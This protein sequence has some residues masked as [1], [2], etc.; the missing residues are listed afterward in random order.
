MP[1][2]RY[3]PPCRRSLAWSHG[4]TPV[5]T[6]ALAG[7]GA[8][9][10]AFGRKMIPD[11]YAFEVLNLLIPEFDFTD[12]KQTDT[13]ISDILKKKKLG[14]FCHDMI[15]ILREFKNVVQAELHQAS[16][17]QYF[18]HTHGQYCDIRD[19]DLDKLGRDMAGR[20]PSISQSVIDRFLPN[21]TFY[22]YLK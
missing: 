19:F 20:F 13:K 1:Y 10:S 18:T 8:C 6:S 12:T 14:D 17:S 22:Y 9:T 5:S 16:K 2:N 11:N 4:F 3:Q 7:S 15:S 21:A